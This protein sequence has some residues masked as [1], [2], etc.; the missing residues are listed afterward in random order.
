MSP[1]FL[2][3]AGNLNMN[4]G[5]A[6]HMSVV[7]V[8]PDRF[9][10]IRKTMQHLQAQTVRD[11]LE[12]VIVAPSF[13]T[14]ELD[15]SELSVFCQFQVIE[16]GEIKSTG[17]AI[18]AGVQQA[19]APVVAYAEEHSYP[20]PT[21]AEALI[22]AHCRAWAAVGAAIAN[23]N[24]GNLISWASLFTDFGPWVEPAKAGEASFLAWH[25]TAYK[26]SVLLDYNSKLDDMLETEGILHRDLRARG[27][28]LYLE[29]AAK[30][31][32]VNVSRPF[33]Y[34]GAQFHGGRMFGAARARHGNWTLF[35]RLLYTGSLPLIPLLRL[36]RVLREIRR[37]GR[38]RELL[39][40]AVPVL[41]IGLV[42]HAI[43]EVTGYALG[44]GD[45][46][47][48]RV[49]FELNRCR[50]ITEQDRQAGC[51]AISPVSPLKADRT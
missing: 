26:R 2:I 7:L 27:H 1:V 41:I 8:T 33:S 16:V 5:S 36:L 38:Q 14:L 10:K 47:Q 39:P 9:D 40:R 3:V 42:A 29:P 28:R 49:S 4:D 32:H 18:A 45:A 51:K 48:R 37:S 12:I 44:A 20:E 50:H 31:Y 6:P 17:R 13:E 34:I 25:H 11:H 19:T 22:N 15:A 24:P 23:A 43:G 46:A 21:W 35:R 30:A